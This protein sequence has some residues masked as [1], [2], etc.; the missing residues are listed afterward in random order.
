LIRPQIGAARWDRAARVVLI[1]DDPGMASL[2]A[3]DL[4]EA[5]VTDMALFG[6]SR[7]EWERAGLETVATPRDPPDRACIDFVSFTHGRHHGDLEA[8]RRYLD[9]ELGL[10]GRLDEAERAV[11]RI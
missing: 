8:A 7:D 11:F 4:A 10:V 1:A 2:A 5:G 6:G 3:V 9:W